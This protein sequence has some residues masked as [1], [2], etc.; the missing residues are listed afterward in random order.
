MHQSQVAHMNAALR[1]VRNNN[2]TEDGNIG[3][4][5]TPIT[6]T[7]PNT[8][9]VLVELP[10]NGKTVASKW[11]F[12]KKIDMDGNVHIY[13]ARLVVKGYT[14]TP[15]IDYEETFSLVA[16]IRAIRILIAIVAYYDYEIWQM[17][18]KT[19]FLNGYLNEENHD[20]PCVYIKASRSNITFLILYVDDILIMGNSIPMLQ[21]VK[22][23]LGK[24]FA[25]KD[26]VEVAYILGIKIY[27][28]RSKRLIGLCQSTY[29]EK[30]LK[31]Y[32][33]ENSKRGSIPMQEKLKLRKSQGAST[34]VE[35]KRMQNVS[36]ARL[37]SCYTDAGYLTDADDLK[38]QTGYVFVLNCGAVDWKSAKQSIF[39]TSSA[40]AEYIAA[41]DASKEYVRK[42]SVTLLGKK[43][44]HP[45]LLSSR[46]L[47]KSNGEGK[48]RKCWESGDLVTL[49][50]SK[51][52]TL[53]V[54]TTILE[55]ITAYI[56]ATQKDKEDD[57]VMEDEEVMSLGI[58]DYDVDGTKSN[59][60][61]IGVSKIGVV[62]V[63]DDD[64]ESDTEIPERHVSPT[65]YD[66][67]LTRRR[68]RVA[69]RYSSPTTS[70]LE[71]PTAPILPASSAIISPSSEF[72]LAPVIAP[73]GIRRRRA[74]LIRLGENIPI[75][76]LDRTHPGRPSLSSTSRATRAKTSS[77][78]DDAPFLIF[79]DDDEDLS[80]V[81][82]LKDANAC[83][84]K[85]SPITPLAWKHHLDN[86]IDLD[87]LDLHDRCY[88][89]Q[90]VVDNVV[91]RRSREFLQ[92]I[93]KLRGK[94]DAM[95]SRER[96]RDEECKGLRVKCE[97]AMTDFEENPAVVALREKISSLSTKAKEHKFI[98]DRMML[99]SQ[100]WEVDELKHAR[101][102]VVS[103]VVPYA[104]M[105]LIHSDDMGSLV[106]KL[107]SSD[108]VYGRCRAFKQ[109][110]GM[111]E[112]FD[113]SKV[114][115]YRSSY[116]KD[117]TQAS[118][119]LAATT[120]PWLD[121]FVADP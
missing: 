111:K 52:D 24:Y 35:M 9:S 64:S 18:I 96:A 81:I 5:V 113:L 97:A 121:E 2:G 40:K 62:D 117:H 82:K 107:V 89:R 119:D 77:S 116:K 73:P 21:S 74:I 44:L 87:L 58:M 15:G 104:E 118:N 78:K 83:H 93:E 63:Y 22:T 92:V 70:T 6:T 46:K 26:L 20:E 105:E 10:P 43:I 114:K 57:M 33:M 69:S 94:C 17:D 85:I 56:Q 103:K 61:M 38:S 14:Q 41:F 45:T 42:K 19:A 66:V 59:A 25:M 106:F 108:I 54:L 51:C 4:G 95:R 80:D 100:K 37:V 101:R 50:G 65:P 102:E 32:C 72:P 120:F 91:N 99:E 98:L 48:D 29:I 23:Y 75:G 36:Y 7:A 12:K 8:G 86:H 1:I 49:M 115:G 60:S 76:R 90:A 67:M 16:N 31:R 28:D 109:V 88:A 112:P 34:P 55:K 27:P 68:S 53:M 39:A 110:A 47:N 79:F 84:L 3:K 13:K 71:I 11:L 30:I